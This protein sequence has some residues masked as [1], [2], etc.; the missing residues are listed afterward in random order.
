M[1][2]DW[3]DDIDPVRREVAATGYWR[4]RTAG[5][6]RDAWEIAVDRL[7]PSQLVS[8]AEAERWADAATRSARAEISELHRKLDEF[9]A[10]HRAETKSMARRVAAAARLV[11]H[12][13]KTVRMAD[14]VA[15]LDL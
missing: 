2:T 7:V 12:R 3:R 14:L 8:R 1:G 9:R 4:A 11:D 5:A 10:A 15:A 6:S 13:R